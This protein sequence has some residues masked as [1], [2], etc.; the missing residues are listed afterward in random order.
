VG[1]ERANAF[2]NMGLDEAILVSRV[3]DSVPNTVRLYGWRPSAVS[4]GRFQKLEQEVYLDKCHELGVDVV[5]RAS[6]GGTVYH[7]AEGEV[8]YCVVSKVSDLGAFDV[9][10]VYDRVYLGIAEALHILGVESDF[11]SGDAKNCPNLTVHG[12][13]IS[14]SSQ[15]NKGGCVLQHGTLL[16]RKDLEKMFNLLRVPW[17]KTCMEVVT[18]AKNK[19]TS[20]QDELGAGVSTS[21]VCGA[22]R[23]GFEKAFG[24][25]FLD[26]KLAPEEL[27]LS[28]RLCKEK[29]S[30]N[31]WS[32]LGKSSL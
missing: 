27:N 18:V 3:E 15:A 20:L 28:E 21:T 4:I 29:Y 25:Q 13:K 17:A 22:M 9:A 6:G 8:T 16:L 30:T 19:I 2:V 23:K 31:D 10:Q 26:G 12:K 5:R 24:D 32:F 1:F 11:N 7:D 14:G